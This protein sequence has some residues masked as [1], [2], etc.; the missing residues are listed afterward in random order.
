M[1]N[2]DLK[3]ENWL[4]WLYE[5]ISENFGELSECDF[6]NIINSELDYLK[7]K[8]EYKDGLKR[9]FEMEISRL[10]NNS[11]DIINNTL[12]KKMKL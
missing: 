2:N 4:R 3:L 7:F 10:F 11:N 9:I 6:K 12:Y 8:Y 1:E 5:D